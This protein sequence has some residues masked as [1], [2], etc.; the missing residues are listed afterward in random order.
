MF[1]IRKA[2]IPTRFSSFLKETR[3]VSV[4]DSE[5]EEKSLEYEPSESE[6]RRG[7]AS[8]S[9][10]ALEA[11]GAGSLGTGEDIGSG[12]SLALGAGSIAFLFAFEAILKKERRVMM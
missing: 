3:V 10:A 2:C 9:R 6:I 7:A 12:R 8:E 4:P 5:S 11:T 1:S